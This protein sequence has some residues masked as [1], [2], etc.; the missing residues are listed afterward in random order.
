MIEFLF[1][2]FFKST[3]EVRVSR[4]NLGHQ[5]SGALEGINSKKL[6][7]IKHHQTFLP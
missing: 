1:E 4:M 7:K 5:T 6:K 3:H 2:M